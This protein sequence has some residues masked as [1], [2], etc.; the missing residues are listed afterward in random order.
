MKQSASNAPLKHPEF[1]HLVETYGAE[2]YVYLWRLFDGSVE[3]AEDCLQ[4]TYLK[5]FQA[6]YRLRPDSNYRA[7]LYK[8]ATNS[9]LT[10]LKKKRRQT[11]F[12]EVLDRNYASSLEKAIEQRNT[13]EQVARAVDAL[14]EKQKSALI[15][16]KY[17]A[18]SY[19]EIAAII[20]GNESSARAN[21]YQGLRK[22]RKM[23][24]PDRRGI[25]GEL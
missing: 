10:S 9:G 24:N 13:L 22:L 18:L 21:V 6:Y 20:G 25:G 5:A 8:I 1:E 7:W 3:D 12:Q 17:Q 23:F 19:E 16:R 2:I 11:D 15:L 4:D 14:P